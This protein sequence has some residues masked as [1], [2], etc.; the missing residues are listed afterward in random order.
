M[1]LL[2]KVD[3]AIGSP[4]KNVIRQYDE[5]QAAD[6]PAPAPKTPGIEHAQSLARQYGDTATAASTVGVHPLE[7]HFKPSG[8]RHQ[9]G[10]GIPKSKVPQ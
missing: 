2:D 1:G 3:S 6:N 4:V 9:L 10:R 5:N 7:E 8:V